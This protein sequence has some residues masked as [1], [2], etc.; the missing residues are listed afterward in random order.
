MT[1]SSNHG[2]NKNKYYPHYTCNNRDCSANPKNITASKVQDDYVD[3][4]RRVAVEPEF[5]EMGKEIVLRLWKSKVAELESGKSS[6]EEDLKKI[7]RQI[8]EFLE[9]IPETTSS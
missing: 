2:K 5:L 6:D 4:L 8:N 7:E 1:G 9:L 3:M